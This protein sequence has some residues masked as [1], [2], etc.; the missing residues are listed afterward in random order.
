MSNF[1]VIYVNYHLKIESSL[2]IKN[3]QNL[4]GILGVKVQIILF[5]C[6]T[7]LLPTTEN[8]IPITVHF[9]W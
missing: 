2:I 9:I 7:K 5:F 6:T 4:M 3:Q 1:S 8:F